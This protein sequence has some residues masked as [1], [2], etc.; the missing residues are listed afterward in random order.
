MIASQDS[1][2]ALRRAVGSSEVSCESIL[3]YVPTN[4]KAVALKRA[5]GSPEQG[6]KY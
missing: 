1:R 3:A 6:C 4:Q 5:V 2:V